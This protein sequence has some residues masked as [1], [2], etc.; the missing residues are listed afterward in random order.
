MTK[1]LTPRIFDKSSIATTSAGKELDEFINYVTDFIDNASRIF[2]NGSGVSDNFDQRIF[3][4]TINTNEVVQLQVG[5]APLGILLIQNPLFKGSGAVEASITSLQWTMSN[6][7]QADLKF[8][9]PDTS[10]MV[11]KILVIYS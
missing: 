11:V 3:T 5:R 2:R 10:K 8:N 6:N 1:L 4:L 9:S 7:Q